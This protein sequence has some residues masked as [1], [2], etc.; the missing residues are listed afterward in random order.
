MLKVWP[1][2]LSDGSSTPPASPDPAGSVNA[3]EMDLFSGDLGRNQAK[4]GPEPMFINRLKSGRTATGV[5]A[6]SAGKFARGGSELGSEHLGGCCR[7]GLQPVGLE[8]LGGGKSACPQHPLC[9]EPSRE[10]QC[11]VR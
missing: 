7:S 2:L 1:S 4:N 9:T 3:K 5:S 8:L 10:A 6:F 11:R